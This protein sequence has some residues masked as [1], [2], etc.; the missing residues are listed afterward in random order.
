MKDEV[1]NRY[2]RLLVKEAV[3]KDKQGNYLWL[4]KC[5][6]GNEVVV[7][8]YNLRNG[9]TKSCGC[10]S[11]DNIITKCRINESGNRYTRL[12]VI[13]FAYTKNGKAY[14]HCK[15]DCG[16]EVDVTADSL[17]RG[18]T[19]SCGCLHREIMSN[20]N[21]SHRM[22]DTRQFNIFLNIKQR[23]NNHNCK[24]YNNYGGRGIKC[25]W[26]SFEEFWKDMGES[27]LQHCEKYGEDQT[28]LERI[29]VNGNYCKENC[30]WAT[31]KEQAN[32][33]RKN[34]FIEVNGETL[35]MKEA[36][37]KYGIRYQTVH[38]RLKA[39][40]DIFGNRVGGI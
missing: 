33:T 38:T 28:T 13:K 15:C 9:N 35:T 2:E 25:L 37:E 26:S 40:K 7:R 31:W 14:W 36:S 20:V 24:S 30:R 1:G 10:L 8:G 19:K 27:Y 39:G 11:K 22:S 12:L 23:C 29:D 5:D 34:H 6:C 32:N 18:N 17:R 3:G 4:C 16:N 21:V